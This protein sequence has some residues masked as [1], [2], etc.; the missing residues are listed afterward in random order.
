MN[1]S[2]ARHNDYYTI[3]R[4][5]CVQRQSTVFSR[6]IKRCLFIVIVFLITVLIHQFLRIQI[7]IT[8]SQIAEI[9]KVNL[10]LKNQ[11]LYLTQ[12]IET[13]K[14]PQRIELLANA[15]GMFPPSAQ[16][17]EKMYNVLYAASNQ[18]VKELSNSGE[19]EVQK[20][21]NRLGAIL[22]KFAIYYQRAEAKP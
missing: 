21:R 22:A 1:Y 18:S 19:Q 16:K 5:R 7:D 3:S 17:T 4:S 11:A 6:L 9:K 14:H 2:I 12:E 15:M 13:L 20:K 8:K 10:S